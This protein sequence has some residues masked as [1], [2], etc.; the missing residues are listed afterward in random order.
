MVLKIDKI[1]IIL[2]DH[3]EVALHDYFGSRIYWE[4]RR[5]MR[6]NGRLREFAGNFRKNHLN[7]TDEHDKTFLPEN[8]QDERVN[9]RI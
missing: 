3:A 9:E 7:S 2:V 1:R 4:A 5:S 8:W 6:F